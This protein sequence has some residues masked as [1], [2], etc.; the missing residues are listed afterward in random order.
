ML[1]MLI[2]SELNY[3]ADDQAF[4]AREDQPR[5]DLDLNYYTIIVYCGNTIK[6]GRAIHTEN[7]PCTVK[8][9]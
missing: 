2:K 4:P 5:L 7:Y 9:Y 1:P 3:K 6:I 8:L